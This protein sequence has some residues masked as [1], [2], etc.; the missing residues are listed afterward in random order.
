MLRMARHL[1]LLFQIVLL[2]CVLLSACTPGVEDALPVTTPTETITAPQPVGSTPLPETTIQAVTIWIPPLLGPDT[3]AGSILSEH[4]RA[5]EATNPQIAVH[6]RVKDE[7]GASGILETL[8]AASLAA[9]STLPDIVVLSPTALHSAALKRLISPLDEIVDAPRL[10]KWYEYA[11]S[12]AYVDGTFVGIPFS[13]EAEAFAYRREAYET[14][15]KK[16]ADLLGASETFLIPL[17]DQGSEFTLL[18]YKEMGGKLMGETGYPTIEPEI[19]TDILEFF[20]SAHEAGIL[21]LFSLQLQS[22]EDT[23]TSLQQGHANSA[24]IPLNSYLNGS[25]DETYVVTP[26][27]T[28]GGLGVIPTR[29]RVWSVIEKNDAQHDLLSQVLLWLQEPE[30]MGQLAF[31][32]GSLPVTSA[33]LDHWPESPQASTISRLI[34]VAFSEP[35]AEELATFGTNLRA[36]I[37][38]VLNGRSTPETAAKNVFDQVAVP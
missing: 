33:S 26:W 31:S 7:N 29:S 25:L 28:R 15:P 22:S 37:E 24:V 38:D 10:P 23:W 11:I 2:F 8:S 18:L 34:R 6:L 3:E 16:W 20:A 32:M 27:P 36:A 14:E 12:A 30:F 17:A 9:P 4:L 5:F 35:S 21:P 1:K 19:L 13:G